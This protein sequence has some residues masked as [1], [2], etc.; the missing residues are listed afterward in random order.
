MYFSLLL[1]AISTILF[2]ITLYSFQQ[3]GL[4]NPPLNN[5]DNFTLYSDDKVTTGYKVLHQLF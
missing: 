3:I 4:L 5:F 2:G 1:T